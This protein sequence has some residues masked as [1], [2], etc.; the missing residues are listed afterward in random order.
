[1]LMR[2]Q[3]KLMRTQSMLSGMALSFTILLRGV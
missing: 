1:M 3:T 2:T